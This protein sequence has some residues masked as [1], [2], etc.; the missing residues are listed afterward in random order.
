MSIVSRLV[1][2]P[3]PLDPGQP[4]PE[5]GREVDLGIAADLHARTADVRAH[6]LFSA[7]IHLRC[8]PK[9]G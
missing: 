9:S 7:S 3:L 8:S 1:L 5:A 2:R 6:R 4:Q